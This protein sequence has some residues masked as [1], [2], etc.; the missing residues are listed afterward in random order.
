MD[1]AADELIMAVNVPRGRAFRR[2]TYRKVGTRR[3]QAIS[4]I[5]FAAA[6]EIEG[7]VVRDI[8][9]AL[10]S[11]APTVVRARHAEGALLGR[12]LSPSVVSDARLA[13]TADIFPIDDIRSTAPYRR[14]VAG[15]LLEEFLT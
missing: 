4:K 8:R 6:A 10:G 14:Q 1:L 9:I 15:N 3:A 7:G 11:V 12:E 5:C 13:L 2:Q